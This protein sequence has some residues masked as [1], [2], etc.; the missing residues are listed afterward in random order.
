MPLCEKYTPFT[1]N[2]IVGNNP[3]R[4]K[5]VQFGIDALGGKKVRPIMIYGPSGTGKTTAA[6]AVAY[7]NGLELVELNA[8][9]YR[10]SETLRKKIL[11]LG[12]TRSLF[13]KRSLIL[14][15]E[16]DE[17]SRLDSAGSDRVILQLLRE[18]RQPIIVIANDYWGRKVGFLRDA[19][20][21]VEFKRPGSGEIM[22]LLEKIAASEHKDVSRDILV[23]IAKRS[24]GDI[25]GAINDLEMMIDAEPALLECLG[26][27]DRKAEIFKVLD[28]IFL[29]SNFDIARNAMNSSDVELDMMLNWIG[30]NIPNKYLSKMPVYEAY[31]SLSKASM[32]S[33]KASRKSYYGYLRYASVLMSSGVSLASNGNV[34]LLTPYAFPSRISRMSK[35]KKSREALNQIALKLTGEL[36]ANKKTIINEH[37]P[38]LNAMI[39]KAI[40][41]YGA[42]AVQEFMERL[43][44][45]DKEEVAVMASYSRFSS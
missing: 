19:V 13:S 17:L 6:H 31:D 20:E 28:K 45:L 24:N 40:E 8:S 4:D 29:S 22:A 16:I 15:D 41:Q 30:Q 27:R 14:F 39:N 37:L 35:T 23:E 3:A 12:T 34:S 18:S 33:E 21:K 32:F 36:H 25:R 11:P 9:D 10:D 2:G 38:V 5:L 42:E 26:I 43:Y 7:S 1:L 44:K